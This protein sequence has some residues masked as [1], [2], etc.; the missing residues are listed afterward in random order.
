MTFIFLTKLSPENSKQMKDIPHLGRMWLEQI[1]GKCPEV[2]FIK[3]YAL[4]GLY[5]FPDIYDAPDEKT[6]AEISIINLSRGAF[7]AQRLTAIPYAKFLIL[8]EEI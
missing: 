4:P 2:K 3:H 8:T 7:E 5:G 1:K 6:A